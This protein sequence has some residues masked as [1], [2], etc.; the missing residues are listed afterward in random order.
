MKLIA[1]S[2]FV[3]ALALAVTGEV[4]KVPKSSFKST[5]I[6][7]AETVLQKSEWLQG[8]KQM[9]GPQHHIV[10]YDSD[11]E[12][13]SE[14][15]E[16]HELHDVDCIIKV[17]NDVNKSFENAKKKKNFNNNAFQVNKRH[18]EDNAVEL[19]KIYIHESTTA[20]DKKKIEKACMDTFQSLVVQYLSK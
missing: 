12:S 13:D 15:E 11:D 8:C 19:A 5:A 9:E 3:V 2:L 4:V 10:F 14:S 20:A 1:S 6:K 7:N 18:F 17:I 16:L